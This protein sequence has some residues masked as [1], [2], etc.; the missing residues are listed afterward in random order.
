MGRAVALLILTVLFSAHSRVAAQD[1][2]ASS[3]ARALFNEGVALA[4][5]EQWSDA[6]ERFERAIALRD[7]AVIAYNLGL[8]LEHLGR[9]VEAA[10]RFRRVARDAAADATM[11]ASANTALAEVEPHIAWVTI[12]IEGDR[13]GRALRVDGHEIPEALIGA[14][15]PVDPGTH[16][17]SLSE[18]GG[19]EV[20]TQ[21]ITMAEGQR[22][23]VTLA[24]PPRPE[25]VPEPEVV[26]PPVQEPVV[27]LTPAPPPPPSD[28]TWLWVGIGAGAAVVVAGIVVTIVL[29]TTPAQASPWS[30]NAG[31]IEVG[32]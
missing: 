13:L 8:A 3:A 10:E 32:R 9:P 17:I 7:S 18:P 12:T 1:A 20:S 5:Q 11:R 24:S 31:V 14:A 27:D 22:E 15:T 6:A 19:A 4:E 26:T 30:G 28:D 29:V 23:S 16:A 25:P 21:S 2:T